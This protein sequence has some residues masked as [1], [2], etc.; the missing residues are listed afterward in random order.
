MCTIK[1]KNATNQSLA[2]AA[3]YAAGFLAVSL[4]ATYDALMKP[5]YW[6]WH[7][8]VKGADVLRFPQG[9]LWGFST[10][11]RTTSRGGTAIANDGA[12]GRTHRGRGGGVSQFCR[13]Q[14]RRARKD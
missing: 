13:F 4:L 14:R 1:N 9:P 7:Q 5:L 10:A 11:A 12:D 8:L 2:L 3:W 6:K